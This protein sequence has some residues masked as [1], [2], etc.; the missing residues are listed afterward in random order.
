MSRIQDL[1]EIERYVVR[2]P[3]TYIE[4]STTHKSLSIFF[5][6]KFPVF[7]KLINLI[8]ALETCDNYIEP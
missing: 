5:Y 8:K 4:K 6:R 2:H 7:F 3:V 1:S